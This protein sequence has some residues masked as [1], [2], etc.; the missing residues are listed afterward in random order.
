MKKDLKTD[1]ITV[2]GFNSK[3]PLTI[4]LM[5]MAR[6]MEAYMVQIPN[7]KRDIRTSLE[8]LRLHDNFMKLVADEV[9]AAD[10]I[11]EKR[12]INAIAREE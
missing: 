8:V 4:S 3:K 6:L 12:T 7:E 11:I 5:V 1:Q 9:E 2:Q 10:E